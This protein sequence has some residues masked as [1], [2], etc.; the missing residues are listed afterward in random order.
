[1]NRTFTQDIKQSLSSWRYWISVSI[2]DIK[3][4]YSRT[5]L[6]PLW[7]TGTVAVT[8]FAMGPLFGIIFQR[9]ID[10]YLLH[11]STGM[12]FWIYISSCISESCGAFIENITIIKNTSK[13]IYI[14]I[15]R[16]ISRNTIVLLH[17]LIIPILIAAYFGYLSMHIFFLMPAIAISIVLVCLISLPVAMICSRYRDFVPLTQ[18][19][20]QLFFFLTPIFWVAGT[21]TERFRLLHLNPFDYIISLLRSPFYG[22]YDI[23]KIG[24]IFIFIIIFFILSAILYIKFYKKLSYW[25]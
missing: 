9:P 15:F 19:I 20:L 22:E 10:S 5:L 4:K 1:M 7:V 23:F 6:G 16:I 25:L 24:V 12:V 8:I 14:Y 18:N 11:L 2:V 13:P 21:N 3:N 17:N